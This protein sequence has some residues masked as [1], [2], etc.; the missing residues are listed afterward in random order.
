MSLYG[1]I[2]REEKGPG[3]FRVVSLSQRK[4]EVSKTK[5]EEK[6]QYFQ[7]SGGNDTR[8]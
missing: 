5:E 3:N 4:Y 8:V 2:A 1:H 7:V 6:N